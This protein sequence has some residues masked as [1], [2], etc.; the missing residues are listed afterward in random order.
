[1]WLKPLFLTQVADN[2]L[3]FPGWKAYV[4]NVEVPIE[5]YD[6]NWRGIIT[7]PVPEGKHNVRVVFEETKLR[8]FA[9]ALS[10]IGI[11]ILLALF[12]KKDKYGYNG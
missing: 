2:T 7:F 10:I 6:Q 3:Y 11:G 5:P 1:M 4:D 8:K 12:V 9:N